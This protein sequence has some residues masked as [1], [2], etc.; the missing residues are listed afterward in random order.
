MI[1]PEHLVIYKSIVTKTDVF[2]PFLMYRIVQKKHILSNTCKH[3]H[4]QS[5]YTLKRHLDSFFLSTTLFE[6]L[7]HPSK[8]TTVI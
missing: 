3:S 5:N 7:K 6:E 1:L 2:P 4:K 8:A